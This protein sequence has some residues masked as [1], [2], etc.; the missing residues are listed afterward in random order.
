V[1]AISGYLAIA[2]LLAALRRV[3]LIPFAV[4]CLVVGGLTIALL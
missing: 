3:G 2:V 1:A 4:Y